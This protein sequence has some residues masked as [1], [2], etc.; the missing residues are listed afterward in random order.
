MLQALAPGPLPRAELARR[1]DAGDWGQERF[2]AV[3]DHGIATHVLVE[4]ADGT[5]RSRYAD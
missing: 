1:V 5:V 4:D 3:V 2:D